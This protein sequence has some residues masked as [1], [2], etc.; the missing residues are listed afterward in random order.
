MAIQI[1]FIVFSSKVICRL[2]V[3][4]PDFYLENRLYFLISVV[5]LA[6]PNLLSVLINVIRANFPKI[7]D[8]LPHS[9]FYQYSFVL[10]G[11]II[12]NLAQLCTLVFG[13][14]HR[15]QMDHQDSISG[16]ESSD[17]NGFFDPRVATAKNKILSMLSTSKYDISESSPSESFS[18]MESSQSEH[19]A[20]VF[21]IEIDNNDTNERKRLVSAKSR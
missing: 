11:I 8:Y 21:M 13:M 5:G 12:P 20:H 10:I 3:F 1:A 19:A 18:Y 4:F 2:S 9:D 15:N 17:S 7:D 14:I 16:S 6:I